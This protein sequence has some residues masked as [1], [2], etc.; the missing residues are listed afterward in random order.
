MG[1]TYITNLGRFLVE[2]FNNRILGLKT[3]QIYYQKQHTKS[4]KQ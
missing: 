2:C 3:W 4:K 1:K